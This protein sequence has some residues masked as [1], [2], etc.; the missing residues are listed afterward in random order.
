MQVYE[1]VGGGRLR[2]IRISC[3]PGLAESWEFDEKTLEYTIHLRKG[4]KWHPMKLPNGKML[5]QKE[6]TARDVKFSFR[7]RSQPARRGRAHPVLLSRIPTRRIRKKRYKI[8]LKVVD[9]Y[10]VKIKWSE[11]YFLSDD[12]H[13]R[14]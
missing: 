5:P 4:V 12:I 8:K 11:P 1:S 14:Q 2:T 13:S 6:F 7:L 3:S 10:T 9:D